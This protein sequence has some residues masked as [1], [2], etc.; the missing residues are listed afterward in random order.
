[1]ENFSKPLQP[2]GKRSTVIYEWLLVIYRLISHGYVR[3]LCDEARLLIDVSRAIETPQRPQGRH[4]QLCAAVNSARCV[5]G[6]TQQL[7]VAA[8]SS[9]NRR[10][11]LQ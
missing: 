6:L 8:V 5:D 3:P 1:M 10:F 7:P 11:V 2:H 9:P 4:H